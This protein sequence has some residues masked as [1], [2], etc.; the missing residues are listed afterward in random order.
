MMIAHKLISALVCNAQNNFIAAGI[1]N[2]EDGPASSPVYIWYKPPHSH[3][4]QALTDIQGPTK[5]I[6]TKFVL[7]RV[8]HRHR[9]IPPTAP[10]SP[11]ASSLI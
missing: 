4:T 9:H 3:P 11:H 6:N 5:S 10:K 2:P 7:C 8:S 1:E